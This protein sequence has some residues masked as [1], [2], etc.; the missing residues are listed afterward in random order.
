MKIRLLTAALA[1]SFLLILPGC[2]QKAEGY[3]SA[4][5]S[6]GTSHDDALVFAADPD[7]DQVFV[8]DTA[9]QQRIAAVKVGSQPE[10]VLVAKDDT[11]FVTNRM[12]RSISV[13]RSGDWAEAAK[14]DVGVEPVAMALT[15]DGKTLYVVSSTSLQSAE[16]G[17]LTAIDTATLQAKWELPVGHEPRG[18]ALLDGNKAMVSLFKDGDV[19][20]VDLSGPK[21]LKSGT[22]VFQRLNTQSL[23]GGGFPNVKEPPPLPPLGRDGFPGPTTSRARGMEALAVSP[24]GRQVFAASRLSSDAVLPSTPS[25]VGISKCEPGFECPPIDLP[26]GISGGDGYGGGS[27]GAT[28]VS[29]PALLTFDENASPLVD[30]VTNCQPENT[31]RPPMVLATGDSKLPIQGPTAAVVDPTGSFLYVV[32]HDSDNVAV[33]STSTQGQPLEG[34]QF[35]KG[36]GL[37]FPGAGRST[38][39]SVISV[40]AGPTGIALARDGKR[41]WVYNSF[42]HSLSLIER[43]GD[44]LRTTNTVVLGSDILSPDVVQG[45]KLFFT[46]NDSRMNNLATGISCGTC[47]L[48]GREDGHV[49]NFSEGPRQTPSLAGRQLVKTAP[50]HWGGEFAS[51]G[52]F[53]SH[54]VTNRMGGKGVSPVMEMQ[55]AAFIASIPA[56]DNPHRRAEPT[57]AQQRGAQVFSQAQC[58]SCHSGEALTDNKFADVGSLVKSGPVRDDLVHLSKGLNTPSL[59]GIARSAPYLHDGSAVTLKARVLEDNGGA[60]GKTKGLTGSQLDDLVAYLQT[61]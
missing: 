40:G 11:L 1:V 54:T 34:E 17:T 14:V 41:A 37:L 45:R 59:L 55:I 36:V 61:L 20:L 35:G 51:I 43:S 52:D 26:G 57:D 16:F 23:Q 48:D 5:G 38:V 30:S 56:A 7:S 4:Q 8:F 39:K 12:G 27:C 24:D 15:G 9:S 58:S 18:L 6:V 49:W 33:V 32:N 10:K 21:L 2:G 22:D 29:S 13:I 60:H 25:S 31:D 46:T 44:A 3:T 53:M 28:S 19:V 50:F 42:D 47:H